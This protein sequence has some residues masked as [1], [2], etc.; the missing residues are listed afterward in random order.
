MQ[1]RFHRPLL[2]SVLW[3]IATC[4][5]AGPGLYP[6]PL[7][8]SFEAGDEQLNCYELEQALMRESAASYSDKP[9]FY[10]DPY[11]GAS[12]WAGTLW[13]P[14]AWSYLAYSGVA[15]YGEYSRTQPA[16][17]RIEALRQLKARLRCH[18]K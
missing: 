16:L 14:G 3:V 9:G 2:L 7:T 6:Q 8:P 11:H 15:E 18:E 13:A 10:D 4:A 12:L 5:S 17:A 1:Q